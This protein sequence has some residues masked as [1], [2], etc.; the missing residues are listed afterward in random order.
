[1]IKD[2]YQPRLHLA[3]EYTFIMGFLVMN[4]KLK[5][6]VFLYAT[7]E[8]GGDETSATHH[9]TNI[10]NLSSL[11]PPDFVTIEAGAVALAIFTRTHEEGGIQRASA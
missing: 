7:D 5:T 1:M 8:S 6:C 11:T 4:S 3:V 2:C 10:Y 9:R